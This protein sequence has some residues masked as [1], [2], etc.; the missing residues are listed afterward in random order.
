MYVYV[1]TCVYKYVCMSIC[2]S[3]CVCVFMKVCVCLSL[4]VFVLEYFLKNWGS[5]DFSTTA[6]LERF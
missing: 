6:Q 4:S 2:G 3:V 5:S 1:V